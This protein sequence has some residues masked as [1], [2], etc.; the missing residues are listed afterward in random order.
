MT[1]F[2]YTH[3]K[4]R[5]VI[6]ITGSDATHFLQGLIT[7]DIN[8]ASSDHLIYSCFLTP[9]GKFLFDFFILKTDDGYLLDVEARRHKE[10]LM[11][12]TMFKL[13][14]DVV[15]TDLSDQYLV[16]GAWGQGIIGGYIDPRLDALGHR[17]MIKNNDDKPNGNDVEFDEYDQH[18]L[19]LCVPDGSRDIIPERSAMLESNMDRLNA[20]DWDKGCYMGQELTAR[21]HYRGLIKRRLMTFTYQG[22][23]PEFGAIITY[24]DE[25]IGEVRSTCNG[26]GLALMK[27]EQAQISIAVDDNVMVND[28][29]LQILK[30]CE[31]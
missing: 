5:T 24:N 15:L 8:K 14:S 18:R 26:V 20:L 28:Q 19:R 17:F 21:T 6:S 30:E 29:A 1:E 31:A 10:F 9:Q 12:L 27:I 22:N 2:F 13:R 11:R 23:A 3:L 16:Y 25:K 4:N 7:N